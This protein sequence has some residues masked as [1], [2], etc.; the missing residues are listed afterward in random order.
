MLQEPI[1][2]TLEITADDRLRALQLIG[3][4][5][6]N[7]S[8]AEQERLLA[9]DLVKAGPGGRARRTAGAHSGNPDAARQASLVRRSKTTW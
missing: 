3:D 4:L 9:L 1:K 2:V 8:A 5:S 6:A 7:E